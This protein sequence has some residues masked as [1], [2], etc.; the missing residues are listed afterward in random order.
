MSRR[1]GEDRRSGHDRRRDGEVKRRLFVAVIVVAYV[2]LIGGILLAWVEA[3]RSGR[4]SFLAEREARIALA[5]FREERYASCL[6]DELDREREREVRRRV[7]LI[8]PDLALPPVP[9]ARDCE[10]EADA[11]SAALAKLLQAVAG[12]NGKG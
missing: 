7:E 9:P 1:S 5:Q 3:D 10:E 2:A 12:T 4:T 11:T 6:Q 8:A